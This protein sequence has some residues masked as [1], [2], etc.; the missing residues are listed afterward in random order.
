VPAVSPGNSRVQRRPGSGQLT[1]QRFATTGSGQ[2]C[3]QSRGKQKVEEKEKE[4]EGGKKK[5]KTEIPVELAVLHREERAVL[6]IP[7]AN[8]HAGP[9]VI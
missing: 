2:T 4:E 7:D 3:T 6:V 9:H 5:K 1:K 8:N